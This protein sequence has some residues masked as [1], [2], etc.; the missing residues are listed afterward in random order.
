M[1]KVIGFIPRRPDISRSDF[2]HYYETQHV[3]LALSR[4]RSF[5]KYVRNHV[6]PDELQEPGFD[7]LPEWW[8]T[9]PE[10]AADI[11]TW[12]ASPA[13]EVLHRDEANFMDRPRMSSCPVS[14]DLLFG[15]QRQVELWLIPKRG[16]AIT[17]APT[18]DPAAFAAEIT[19]FGAEL[20]RRNE[21]ALTRVSRDMPLDPLQTSYPLDALFWI[22][23]ATPGGVIEVPEHGA[24]ICVCTELGFEAIETPPAALS[25]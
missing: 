15:P 18:A 24:A 14:D 25:V 9:S 1:I 4:I 17:R 8:F 11:A 2:R 7:C 10:V 21:G 20:I 5:T 3:L 13:G 22:W 19:R 16:L 23:P 12:V 6:A